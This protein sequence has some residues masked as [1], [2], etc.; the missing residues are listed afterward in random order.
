MKLVRFA[1]NSI[2]F[3]GVQSFRQGVCVGSNGLQDLMHCVTIV[4]LLLM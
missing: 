4:Y 3:R 2:E 1:R